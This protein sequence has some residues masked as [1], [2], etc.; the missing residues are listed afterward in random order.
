ME[1]S[2][3]IAQMAALKVFEETRDLE[4]AKNIFQDILYHSRK[5]CPGFPDKCKYCEFNEY[6]VYSPDF[7]PCE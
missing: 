7:P 6:A 1:K 3:K 5:D 2:E 4:M